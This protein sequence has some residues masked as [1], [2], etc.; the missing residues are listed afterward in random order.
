MPSVAHII[1]R[2]HNRK[3]RLNHD[4][5]R[6]AIWL[7]VIYFIPLTLALTPPLAMLGLSIWLYGQAASHLPTPQA[8]VFLDPIDGVTRFYDRSDQTEIHRLDDPLGEA[9]RWLRLDDLPQYIIDATLLVEGRDF[10]EASASYDP[11]DTAM[12]LWRYILGLPPTTDSGITGDLVRET[13]LPRALTSGLDERLLEIVLISESRRRQSS[14]ELLEWRLNSSSYSHDAYGIDAAAQ[15]YFG[16]RAESLTLSEAAILAGVA[17]QPARNPI[18]AEASSRERGADLLFEMFN[19]GLI[20]SAD[21]EAASATVTA[22]EAP[23]DSGA[24]LAPNFVDYAKRQSVA[25]LER[26]GMDGARLVARGGLRITTSLDLDLQRQ[27]ECSLQAHLAQ[28]RGPQ[29]VDLAVGGAPCP[30]ASAS[31]APSAALD[32][33]PD[34]GA[35]TLIDV[36]SGEILSLVGD[37]LS[38][39]YQPAIVLHPF[40]YMDAFLRRDFTPASMVYDIPRS[41]PGPS[42]ELIYAP[43]NPDGRYRGPLNLRD[44]MAAGLL[45]PTVQVAS[46]TGVSP[47]IHT[48]QALGFNSLDASR[49]GLDILERGGA[50]SVLDTAYAYSVLAS[51]GAMRG[52]E[53]LPLADGYR[54]RDPVAVLRIEDAQG[55]VLWSY[56][57]LEAQSKQS[58][59]VEPSLAYLINDILADANARQATL[60]Q[61]D[62]AL[63]LAR[64]VAVLDG[65]SADKRDGW[66]VGY[67]PD[68]ALIVHSGRSDDAGMSIDAYQRLGSAP[69]WQSLMR[70]AHDER[71]LPPRDWQMPADIEE[72]LVC[73]LSGLLPA[74]TDH[75][76][77]RSELM[78]AGSYLRRDDL[79]QIVEINRTTGQLATVNTPQDLRERV[80]YFVPPEEILDWWVENDKPLPP[81]SYSAD[82]EAAETKAVQLTSPA[83]FAYVGATVDV[84]GTINQAG[85]V[86]WRLE[87]GVEVNPRS[88]FAIGDRRSVDESGA[89][90]ATWETALLSGIHTLRLTVEFADGSQETDTKLLTFDNTPPSVTLRTSEGSTE[91]LST[92]AVSLLAEVSDNLTIERVEFYQ[93]DELLFIDRD[94]P[95]G[96]EHLLEGAGEG[97][98]RA[99]AFD[100]VGNRAESTLGASL[101]D[102]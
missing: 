68:L 28:A 56:Q 5:R 97:A 77:T 19:A 100:Q 80:S 18:D 14:A 70:I 81:S 41:Y 6:S 7:I 22:I 95:Y 8:T 37:A 34:K 92:Q 61:P 42:A 25:I 38:P 85:A 64:P 46:A 30:A 102:R 96:H 84:A 17:E 99:V 29:S 27:A 75:C 52:L 10:L 48:A 90:S 20:D 98:F 94:W 33:P 32:S 87:Y 40:V 55:R 78:P 43:T 62:L 82:R 88:W 11:L 26:L 65:L 2:R 39:I 58:V 76:P 15:V 23:A 35:L 49:A 1:R 54:G 72:Y 31:L 73:E 66:T 47:A 60:Q 59:I 13:M 83:D 91:I 67:T 71:E 24:D 74:T 93:D 51:M 44:A 21:Y 79:W 36:G 53:T 89:V 86:S 101:V 45:P 4:Q 9:R 16:K 63:Q 3:R 57:Q 50:V 69:I 12:Q